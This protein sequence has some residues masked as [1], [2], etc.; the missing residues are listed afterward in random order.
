MTGA[1]ERRCEL[2]KEREGITMAYKLLL[3]TTA[4]LLSTLA[5]AQDNDNGDNDN[6]DN[7]NDYVLQY[8]VGDTFEVIAYI[9]E[10]DDPEEIDPDY[11][12][13]TSWDWPEEV[14]LVES[15][16]NWAEFEAL[17]PTQE[18][19]SITVEDYEVT[20]NQESVAIVAVDNPYAVNVIHVPR[21]LRIRISGEFDVEIIE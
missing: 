1:H 7:D 15:T 13:I 6:G 16:D 12:V 3:L 20:L 4:L 8:E 9:A 17:T 18:P 2:G 21:T 14:E 5:V 11:H 19:V 10:P